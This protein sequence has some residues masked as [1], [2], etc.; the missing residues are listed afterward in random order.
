MH[1]FS[2]KGL[3]QA[4]QCSNMSPDEREAEPGAGLLGNVKCTFRGLE[5]L[6]GQ[7]DRFGR[8]W[9][10]LLGRHAQTP[11]VA[12]DPSVPPAHLAWF[13]PAHLAWFFPGPP[14]LVSCLCK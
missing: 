7:K 11:V 1:P 9:E 6:G 10:G 2:Q 12:P 5:T 4:G 13:L 14:G 8:S 3:G